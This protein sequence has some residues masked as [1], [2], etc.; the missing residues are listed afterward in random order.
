MLVKFLD[1]D[2]NPVWVNPVHVRYLQAKGKG[3][4][5]ILGAMTYVRVNATPEEAAQSISEAMP[6]QIMLV[7]DDDED[8][9]AAN[10][11]IG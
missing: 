11:A 10:A 3:T 8:A 6:Q 4:I 7:A 9:A 5:L 1:K 2:D